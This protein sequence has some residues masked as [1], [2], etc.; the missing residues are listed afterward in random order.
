MG[1]KKKKVENS[2]VCP[3]GSPIGKPLLDISL[4]TTYPRR[5]ILMHS[6]KSGSRHIYQAVSRLLGDRLAL[7]RPVRGRHSTTFHSSDHG[8]DLTLS[9][10]SYQPAVPKSVFKGRSAAHNDPRAAA[11][12]RIL[13]R[14]LGRSAAAASCPLPDSPLTTLK[15]EVEKKRLE[16]INSNISN[17]A[18]VKMR[19]DSSEVLTT[20]DFSYNRFEKQKSMRAIKNKWS[21]QQHEHTQPQRRHQFVTGLLDRNRISDGGKRG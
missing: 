21:P 16:L 6:T 5:M 19:P 11:A 12:P 14:T 18:S 4:V 7:R 8:Y 10:G 13:T 1:D 2:A 9:L 15:K 20:H 17:F 3:F